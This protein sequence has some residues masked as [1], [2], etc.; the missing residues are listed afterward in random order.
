MDVINGG[1]WQRSGNGEAECTSA[2]GPSVSL[3]R[4]AVYPSHARIIVGV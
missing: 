2:V 3:S 1:Q 4:R